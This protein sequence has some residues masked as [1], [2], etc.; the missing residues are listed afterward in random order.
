VLVFAL[1]FV[2]FGVGSGGGI[3]LGDLFN[4]NTNTP[5]SVSESSARDRIEKNPNDAQ[6]HHDLATALQTEGDL[7]GAL[8]EFEKYV[9]LRPRSIEGLTTLAGLH[10]TLGARLQPQ[11]QAVQTGDT[12][13][14]PAFNSGVQVDSHTIV[15]PNRIF[16]AIT[17]VRNNRLT[18]L[19]TQQQED[20]TAAEK[21]YQRVARL[22]PRDAPS[23][24]SL[25]T[26]AQQ[27]GDTATA[28]AAY[29]R[30]IALAPDDPTTPAVRQQI[31]ALQQASTTSVP[32]G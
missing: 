14:L 4:N 29:R 3:G 27:A 11:V 7:K 12:A 13:L 2:V 26:A 28:I 31:R 21:A 25:G 22:Q 30:F 17:N 18:E 32:G 24:L 5:G 8:A 19:L 15:E 10:A 1:G 23:Q 6:A 9:K 16:E 20:F